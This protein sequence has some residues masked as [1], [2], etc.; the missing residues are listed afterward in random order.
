MSRSTFARLAI[1]FVAVNVIAAVLVAVTG[2][3]TLRLFA[4]RLSS[5]HPFRHF[6]IAVIL[7]CVTYLLDPAAARRWMTFVLAR[8]DRAAAALAVLLACAVLVAGVVRGTYCACGA[9]AYGYVSQ[10]DLWA[11]NHLIVAQPIVAGVPWPD[12]D[13]TFAP[14][15]YRPAIKFAHLV[16]VYPPGLPMTM[17]A[18]QHVIGASGPY[19]VVPILGALTIWLTF[20]LARRCG[21]ARAAALAAAMMAASPTLAFQLMVPTSDVPATAWWL[22]A[23]VLMTGERPWK[24]FASG[25][26]SGVAILTRPNLIVLGGVLAAYALWSGTRESRGRRAVVHVAAYV[27]GIIP[28]MLILG[29]V[30]HALYGSPLESGYGDF[31]ALYSL[32]N[33]PGNVWRYPLWLIRLETPVVALALL[34]PFGLER[35]HVDGAAV[36]LIGLG[37]IIA[38]VVF[39]SYVFYLPFADQSFARFMLPALPYLLT[40]ASLV[41]VR[42][43]RVLPSDL[44]HAILLATMVGLPVVQVQKSRDV[45]AYNQ[46]QAQHRA[47][48]VARY[49]ER[50]LPERSVL[51]SLQH[52]GSVRQYADRL[53]LRYDWLD[54]AWLDRAIATLRERGYAPVILLEEWEEAPFK[55]RFASQIHGKLDWPPRAQVDE[56]IRV[57]LYDPVDRLRYLA[58]LPVET[59]QVR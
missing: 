3:Y 59:V 14:I 32:S 26:V 30:N 5:H 42:L 38:A 9:D 52:S 51:I 10:A 43:V 24:H 2:G 58:R 36:R 8:L 13:W 55:A 17:A 22:L 40:C 46:A 35:S 57:R 18:L 15:G 12:A 20:S 53:S 29:I 23:V 21:S 48:T 1:M 33:F 11:H 4:L 37:L 39:L 50:S 19:L 31:T 47:L 6:A 56:F 7:A 45:G 25:L 16:P 34:A 44:A 54:P 27:C 49:V 28:G 41:T